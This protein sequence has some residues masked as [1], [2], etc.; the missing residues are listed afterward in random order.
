MKLHSWALTIT[1]NILQADKI[2]V[3][4]A[5][6]KFDGQ[7]VQSSNK[8]KYNIWKTEKASN[9]LYRL[10]EPIVEDLLTGETVRPDN[11]LKMKDVQSMTQNFIIAKALQAFVHS[12]VIPRVGYEE[13]EENAQMPPAINEIK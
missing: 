8:N 11:R 13:D 5:L 2:D 1:L 10:T 9:G 12:G 4:I 7:L 3:A 6:Y